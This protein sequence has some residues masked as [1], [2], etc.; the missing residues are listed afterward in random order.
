MSEPATPDTENAPASELIDVTVP[1]GGVPPLIVTRKQLDEAIELLRSGTGPVGIDTE[2][3][4][5]YRYS[6]RAYLVQLYRQGSGTFIIDPIQFDNLTDVSRELKDV[7][8]IFHAASQDLPS[9][10]EAGY[11]PSTIFD[12]ELSARL[13]GF[14][15]VGLGAVVERLLG[16]HLAKA[17]SAADW[18][19]RPLPESW[20]NYAALDVQL[21]PELREIMA[22]QLRDSGK[23][24]YALEDFDAILHAEPKKPDA[25]RWRRISGIHSLQKAQQLAVVRA[26]WQSRDALAQKRDIAP[27]RIIHDSA[28]IAAAS[29]MPA[30][31]ADL[32]QLSAFT[33][34]NSR[35][36]LDYWFTAIQ[37]GREAEPP[38]LR[39]Q[40]AESAVPPLKSWKHRNPEAAGRLE[41]A[42]AALETLAS[43]LSMPTEN[44]LSPRILR[45]AAWTGTTTEAELAELMITNGARNWQVSL[46]RA[47]ILNAF[48]QAAAESATSSA[49]AETAE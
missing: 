49:D 45:R 33:G 13:L 22:Q 28:I 9:L 36:D 34:K 42:R 24:E 39:A 15:R 29:A 47:P 35:T 25:D 18:S 3:A 17:H 12:T 40:A 16:I 23:W 19:T 27:G 10:K 30:T 48:A 26:L 11:E 4:S 32:A 20:I 46:T 43:A 7:E 14:D 2:R 1:R 44:L 38:A 6:Q 37:E 5:G 8:H 31:K 21:L 41:H